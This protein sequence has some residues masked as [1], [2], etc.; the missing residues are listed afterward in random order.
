MGYGFMA[1]SAGP[2]FKI[3]PSISFHVKCK[4]VEEVDALW[5]K[6]SVGGT[7]NGTW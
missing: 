6:I 7:I 1:I 4:T 2:L 3:N 5:E